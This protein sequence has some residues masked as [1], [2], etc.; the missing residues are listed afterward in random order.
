MPGEP[1]RR[2]RTGPPSD[3][4]WSRPAALAD[5]D[6]LTLAAA[7]AEVASTYPP[8]G[9]DHAALVT[10]ADL[11]D[12]AP[13]ITVPTRVIVPAE[14]RLVLPSSGHALAAAIPG[15][16]LIEIEGAGHIF[17]QAQERQWLALVRGFLIAHER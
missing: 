6:E 14:D 16:E 7:A 11:H 3:I 10:R 2:S 15:A 4:S 12:V 8:G 17:D 9:D 1:W 13:R 5:L